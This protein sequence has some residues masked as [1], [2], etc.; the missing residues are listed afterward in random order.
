MI[1]P[2]V[3]LILSSSKMGTCPRIC[4]PL[5]LAHESLRPRNA[6]ATISAC[7]HA[8]LEEH[9]SLLVRATRW[10]FGLPHE[11]PCTLF[12]RASV[13]ENLRQSIYHA[14]RKSCSCPACLCFHRGLSIKMSG[15]RGWKDSLA[16][17]RNAFGH[18]TSSSLPVPTSGRHADLVLTTRQAMGH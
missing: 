4:C 16:K 11:E 12:V 10:C 15:P 2:N 13:R 5:P 18:H 6:T 14:A 8:H 17:P 7:K 3:I 9:A 1:T